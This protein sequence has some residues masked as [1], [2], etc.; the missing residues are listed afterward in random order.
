MSARL[1]PPAAAWPARLS[2][3]ALALLTALSASY[4]VLQRP[5]PA[6][7]PA[8]ASAAPESRL[9]LT[10]WTTLLGGTAQG[11]APALARTDL[12]LKGLMAGPA[13]RSGVALLAINGA[14]PQP[15]RVGDAVDADLSVAAVEPQAVLLR[16]RS[17]A[18][19]RLDLPRPVVPTLSGAPAPR[20]PAQ[21]PQAIAPAS[22]TP[23]QPPVPAP[24][25]VRAAS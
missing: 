7:L 8:P 24:S 3:F 20:T 14:P 22:S 12:V 23:A 10:Q 13:G 16:S 5:Q 25:L 18:T 21:A 6:P 9:A 2:A 1:A 11:E 19:Q 4:W 15:L 17:G